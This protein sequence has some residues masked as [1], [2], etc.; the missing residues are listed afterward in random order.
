MLFYSLFPEENRCI[1]SAAGQLTLDEMRIC[2]QEL[3]TEPQWP[4]IRTIVTDLRGCW[5]VDTR[6]SDDHA[7]RRME[8]HAF[9]QRRMIWLTGS[10]TVLGTLAMAENNTMGASQDAK[11]FRDKTEMSRSLGQ[12]DAGIMRCLEELE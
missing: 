11:V 4:N 12:E 10:S 1:F 7:R 2:R 9:G 3:G 5:D 6:F 8:H